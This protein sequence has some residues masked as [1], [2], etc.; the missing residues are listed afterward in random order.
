MDESEQTPAGTELDSA[1]ATG[2]DEGGPGEQ[3][4]GPYPDTDPAD[5]D[6]AAFVEES[7]AAALAARDDAPLPAGEGAGSADAP[8]EDPRDPEFRE[9]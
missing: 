5:E 9:P 1:M 2:D 6:G 3:G 7:T 4:P 8:G